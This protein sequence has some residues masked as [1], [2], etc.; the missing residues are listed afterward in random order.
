MVSTTIQTAEG[1]KQKRSKLYYL[2]DWQD[3][4]GP[5]LQE[6]V[7]KVSHDFMG[8]YVPDPNQESD[9]DQ[10]GLFERDQPQE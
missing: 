6:I 5:P 1:K 9:V 4:F 7:D 8:F 10:L 3:S 2:A